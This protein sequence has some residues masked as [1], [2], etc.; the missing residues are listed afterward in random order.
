M[1]ADIGVDD[2]INAAQF[3]LSKLWVDKENCREW[4][5]SMKNYVREWDD[6][7]GSY[8][9]VPYHNWASHGA[10]EFR[11]AAVCESQMSNEMFNMHR[12]FHDATIEIYNHGIIRE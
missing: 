9:D 7:R 11:Y 2:G 1:V 6:K 8:K 5:K 4:I 10:D 3:A 12:P